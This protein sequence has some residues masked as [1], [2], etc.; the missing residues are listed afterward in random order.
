MPWPKHAICSLLLLLVTASLA[1][2]HPTGNQ[3]R[4][5]ESFPVFAPDGGSLYYSM[6]GHPQNLGPD[7]AADVWI[8]RRQ[9]DGSWS[10]PIICGSPINTFA[11]DQV[12]GISASGKQLA[13]LHLGAH[14]Y[15]DLL[16]KGDR[17]W[18]IVTSW[19]VASSLASNGFIHFD[20]ENRRLFYHD[21]EGD[22]FVQAAESNGQW[23]SP[24]SLTGFNSEGFEERPYLAQDGQT[25]YFKRDGKWMYGRM[26]INSTQ[27]LEPVQRILE[28]QGISIESFSFAVLDPQRLAICGIEGEDTWK[29]R[30]L[31]LP[32]RAAPLPCR[33]LSGQVVLPPGPDR[34]DAQVSLRVDGQERQVEVDQSGNYTLIINQNAAGQVVAEAQG[35]FAPARNI[36]RSMASEAYATTDDAASSQDYQARSAVIQDLNNRIYR[37]Q[38]ALNELRERRRQA[39]VEWRRQLEAAGE[40]ILANYI[41]PELEALRYREANARATLT[42]TVPPRP[43]RPTVSDSLQRA[44]DSARY[45]ELEQMRARFQQFQDD[46]LAR[47][48]QSGHDWQPTESPEPP[49]ELVARTITEEWMPAAAQDVIEEAEL[50]SDEL[51][52]NVSRDLFPTTAPAVYEREAWENELLAGVRPQAQAQLREN[53]REPLENQIREREEIAQATTQYEAEIERLNDSLNLVISAQLAAENTQRYSA[54][55]PPPGRDLRAKTVTEPAVYTNDPR[56]LGTQGVSVDFIPLESGR[57]TVLELVTFQAGSAYLTNSAET[58]LR[59]LLSLL[60]SQPTLQILLGVHLGSNMSYSDAQALSEGRASSIRAWF[61]EQGVSRDRV[62]VEAFGRSRP[63]PIESATNSGDERVELVIR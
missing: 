59:R 21:E 20:I 54:P 40:D 8:V 7:N 58:E 45:A 38:E 56:P 34:A 61:I 48:G 1:A 2:Q 41:D 51:A 32:S 6:D 50:D 37:S 44:I 3:T 53:L 22:L 10:R 11:H 42:D 27:I 57:Q 55:S 28:W 29:I 24:V 49:R 63:L 36:S 17:A 52:T 46:E 30:S 13:V 19:P 26:Q 14:P 25:L 23:G 35:Y 39:D 60:Q 18:R 15:L 47:R 9:I 33:M 16:A 62:A 31:P 5:A 43:I 4:R 12:V